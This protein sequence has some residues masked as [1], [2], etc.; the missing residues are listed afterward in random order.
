MFLAENC[1]KTGATVTQ[2]ISLVI[3]KASVATKTVPRKAK[4]H[5]LNECIKGT[6]I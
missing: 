2:N 5:D 1:H 6:N 4:G 3:N